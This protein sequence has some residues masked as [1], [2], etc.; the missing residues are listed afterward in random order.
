M[1]S[2]IQHISI[3]K[4]CY[5][6][7]SEMQPEEKGKFCMHCQKNVVDFTKLSDQEIV[8]VLSSTDKVCGRFTSLQ[9][10]SLNRQLQVEHGSTLKFG[11]LKL[12]AVVMTA[13]SW[14]TIQA[15]NGT[16]ATGQY[17]N[18]TNVAPTHPL[19]EDTIPDRIT[20]KVVDEDN[21]PI[22]GAIIKLIGADG[23]T[24][25]D[26]NGNFLLLVNDKGID[27]V[28]VSMVGYKT[29]H[30]S[31]KNENQIN[32]KMQLSAMWLGEVAVVTVKAPL[33]KRVWWRIRK[34]F[35]S[36]FN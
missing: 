34:P 32:L 19:S 11:G 5:K 26:L 17:Q 27:S 25:T 16:A 33:H 18:V 24:Q 13:F 14:G 31:I 10:N 28:S 8:N 1:K 35:K 22:V 23:G 20:G 2:A 29:S 15:K 12:A 21:I 7:W 9:I 4:P 6:N 36:L 30:F 3:P